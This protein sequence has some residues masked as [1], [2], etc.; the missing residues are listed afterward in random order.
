MQQEGPIDWAR[1]AELRE[2]V[3]AEALEEVVELFLEEVEA[4]T[5]RLAATPDPDRLEA[6]LHFL[7]GSALNLG[8]AEMAAL[9][10]AG[11]TAAARGRGTE[12]EVAAL[13]ACYAVSKA[14]FLAGL[15][16][17]G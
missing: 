2:E 3:G 9:C 17:P 13:L 14:G 15:D 8:F 16:D 11:E 5:D 1:V 12:V 4:V 7:K 6:D 10:A